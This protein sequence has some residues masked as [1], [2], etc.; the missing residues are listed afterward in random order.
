MRP[1]H[2]Q[3]KSLQSL[4]LIKCDSRIIIAGRASG[5]SVVTIRVTSSYRRQQ[6]A[7]TNPPPPPPHRW[8]NIKWSASDLF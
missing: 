1:R 6:E 7:E 2:V 4:E 8:G 3:Y 5:Q